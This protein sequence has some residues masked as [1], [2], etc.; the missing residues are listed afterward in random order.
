MLCFLHVKRDIHQKLHDL[1]ISKKFSKEY[2]KEIFGC[3]VDSHYYEGLVD[4]NSPEEFTSNLSKCRSVWDEREMLAR[5]T[6][7]PTF[8]NWFSAYYSDLIKDKMLKPVRHRA[9]LGNP[10]CQYTTNANESVNS[11]VKDKVDYKA[12]EL[13]IFCDKFEELV[14]TQTR[15]IE[16]AFTIGNGPYRVSSLYPE[17][18]QKPSQW[19]K[20]SKTA[21][22]Q[23]L[24]K[25][26][27]QQQIK[28]KPAEHLLLLRIKSMILRIYHLFQCLL[29]T[30]VYQEQFINPRGTKLLFCA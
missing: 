6:T 12:S 29:M 10:P 4:C 1:G 9:G 13:H 21:K 25:V 26:Q 27:Q 20:L 17:L 5:D 18:I 23:F 22:Q 30:L 15:N 2:T 7:V 24:K 28:S 14:D 16:R 19:L 3:I 8:F 11:R